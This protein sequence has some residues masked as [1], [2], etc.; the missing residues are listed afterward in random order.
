MR[1][2]TEKQLEDLRQL[3]EEKRRVDLEEKQDMKR[4]AQE[5]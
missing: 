3:I 1:N 2:F 5:H 4:T